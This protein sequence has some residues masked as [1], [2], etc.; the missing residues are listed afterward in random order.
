MSNPVRGI[1]QRTENN[2]RIRWL[3][4]EEREAL[5]M[6]TR[7]SP[8]ERLHLLVLVALGTGCRLGEALSLTW[9]GIDFPTRTARLE[10]TKNGDSRTLTLPRPVIAELLRHRVDKDGNRATGTVFP[11]RDFRK[12][13]EQAKASAGI[14]NL[15]FHDLRHDAASQLVMNGA[16]LHEVAEVLGHRSVQTSARYAHLSVAHKKALT[17]KVLGKKLRNTKSA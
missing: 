16:T 4:D 17:D 12:F 11:R 10:R 6:A 5:L 14:E 8:W 13:W 7:A 9:E 3:S 2:R 1:P 15:R